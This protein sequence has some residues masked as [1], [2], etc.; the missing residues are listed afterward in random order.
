MG[1]D[2]GWS[3]SLFIG[4][5]IFAIFAPA[6]EN[7]GLNVK[8]IRIK[9][10]IKKMKKSL[11]ALFPVSIILLGMIV[12]FSTSAI[13]EDF[14][15]TDSWGKHGFE[16]TQQKST[17]VQVNYSIT[18]FSIEDFVLNGES[19]VNIELPG[20]LLFN[21]EGAPNLPGSGRYL[22]IPEGATAKVTITSS[23]T[24]SLSNVYLAPA[25]RIPWET[26]DGPLDYNKDEAIYTRDAFYP[27]Q[28]VQL[29]E[30]TEIR[31]VDAVMLGVTP[32]Q[33]NPVTHELIIYRDLKVE[34]SFEGGNGY[35]GE[36]RLRSRWWDPI[37]ADM[38]LNHE[39][40]PKMNYNKSYQ[41]A[42]DMGCE[43]LIITPT[44][45]AFLQWADSIKAF[46]TQQGIQTDIMTVDD[47]GGNDVNVLED[48]FDD[49][50]NNW[51]VVP[52]AVLIIGDYGTNSSNRITSPIWSNYCV[53]DN[54]WA[55]VTNN[56]MPDI[57]FARLTAEDEAQLEVMV[58]KFLDYERTPPT[59]PDFYAKPISALGFQTERW[60]QICSEAVAGFWENEQGREPVRINKT[61]AGNPT[62]DPWS[63]ATNT[64]TVVN[65]FGP[66]GL[67][68]IPATPGS[69]NCTWNGTAQ[70]VINAINDGAFMLQHRD[71][72]FEQGWGEP[73]FQTSHISS[74][75]NTDLT[76]VW[77]I[78]CL[79]GKYNYSGEVFSERFHRYTYNGENSG[80]L[81][82]NAASEVSY[83]FVNDTYVWGAF[84]NMWPD[85]LPD[86]GSTPEERG[87]LPAFA[88]AAG[89][90]F[91]QA[92]SWP[93]NTSNKEVTYN[94]FHHHGDAFNVVYSSVPEMLTVSHDPI[95][96][97]GVTSFDVTAD[98]GA[99]IALTVNGEIIGTAE[100]T[101]NVVSIDIPGQVPPDQV[102]VTITK[103]NYYRYS[104]YV[105]VIP[106]TGPYVVKE[107]YT[108]N[109][110][111]GNNNGMMDYG[112]SNMLSL[113]VENVGVEMAENVVVTLSSTDEYITITDGEET[114]GNIE[115]GSLATVDDAFAY[116]V[117][118]DLPDGHNAVIEVSATD[119]TL[120][121]VSSI[122]IPGHSPVLEYVNFSI[123]DASGNGNGKIDP[124]E[125]VN[126][127]VE[128][129][130]S[131]S[132]DAFNI[133]GFLS[134]VDPYLT[135]TSG[136]ATFGDLAF[137]ETTTAVFTAET[138]DET[139]AGHMADLTFEMEGDLGITGSGMFSVVI[140]QIPILILD[141]DGNSNSAPGM[142]DA[143]AD[144]EV[145]YETLTS[146][147]ADLNLYSTVFV[148]LGVYSDN[149]VLSSAEGQQLADY[150][151]AGGALYM[152]GG[153]TW[154]YDN[155]TAVHGM[156]N[157]NG[158]ADGTSDMGNVEGQPDT[159]TEGMS[160]NYSGDNSWMDHLEPV[161]PA[162]LILENQSPV[163][164][165]AV[166]YDEGTYRTIG[167][168]HE[169]GGLD[170]GASPSTKQELMNAYL[171]FLGIA[172]SMQASFG[173]NATEVCAPGT[174]EF[175]DQSSGYVVSW[176]WTFEGGS[177]STSTFQ[178][179]TVG[180]FTPGAYDVTLEVSDGVETATLTL[181]D[182]IVV[183]ETPEQAAAPEGDNE[184]CT[185]TII[186][187][188]Y[189]TEGA[190]Y[191]ND[192]IWEIDPAEAGTIEGTGMDATVTWT[193]NWE[194][195]A[196]VKVKGVNDCGEGEFSDE[197]EVLCWVCT[198]VADLA[199]EAG[200]AIFPNPS[201]GSFTVEFNDNFGKTDV[202]VVNLLN[203][204]VY[205]NRMET[206]LGTSLKID[207]GDD[208]NGLYFVKLKNETTEVVSKII[209]R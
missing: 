127:T 180:Y 131:G 56:D 103:Q 161:S 33:Y 206:G 187:T 54:I 200:V 195:T 25:P 124:G 59:D 122:S 31:G 72:G 147:P 123:D 42:E 104:T 39:S 148:C 90:Y 196:Y 5:K 130:N 2:Y 98:E 22:A 158:V 85:F 114:Y 74:L 151:N 135:V 66:N 62:S 52:S 97:A 207:L 185:N 162:V 71:H 181:E 44:D 137:G 18:G 92:S 105:E 168:S 76:F 80:A 128:I 6:A 60:F 65:L 78:N 55:D 205:E 140:G 10:K 197:Y 38:F 36:D 116:D 100:A 153:D 171:E 118:N 152:E 84:D 117:A 164:G 17:G 12:L 138:D 192:Y 29:G 119:G 46:R 139:P 20:N 179:P 191:A 30:V 172:V 87:V 113:T 93:Y 159:F 106:P 53:S 4:L 125:T 13:A 86:Y 157:A 132:S 142:E 178:N 7:V 129:E 57:I 41:A 154:A 107:S 47:A 34:V 45:A 15:Y 99:F 186:S 9:F 169:F 173:S 189:S 145:A 51:D 3:K 26:E 21:D 176:L 79:T 146:F 175:T 111:S 23:R 120:T 27:E 121:W 95:L 102:L 89:K 16:L 160:F 109:D 94:L 190:N 68:Y 149:H 58:T 69:V 19:M 11:Q 203:E 43:Y 63:T 28:P 40:L 115:A 202:M 204:V 14:R 8:N 126:F 112:E 110:A 136:T 108:I 81:A 163:Y 82:I 24:E 67:G 170:D 174:V 177:P 70:D 155:S 73:A 101:G 198:G 199:K 75:T 208:A 201:N 150:L 96:Y 77:S 91:L 194:G 133:E 83:S 143:I 193:T 141:L 1:G 48:F 35:F 183:L 37:M 64:S 209:I 182:Y 88:M 165:T 188:D 167:A 166:A 184:I 50:Y 156:F 49:A 144:M 134:A 32:F 61:Y